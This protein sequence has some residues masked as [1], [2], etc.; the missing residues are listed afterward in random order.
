MTSEV[1]PV[2]F[3]NKLGH[4]LFGMVHR[5]AKPCMSGAAIILLSPGVKM[6][7]A[8]HRLYLD[9]S[10]RFV[11]LGYTVLRFD[12]YGLGD[13]EGEVQEEYLA[14]LYGAVQVGRYI[15]DTIAAMDWMQRTYGVTKFIASGLC[16]GAITGL[17]A[18]VKDPRI[19]G[20][21]GLAIPV[22]IDGSR[23]DFNRYMTDAQLNMTRDG[24][25][26]KLLTPKAWRSW[27]RLL[28]FQSDY[29]TIVRSLFKPVLAKLRKGNPVVPAATGS[30]PADNTNPYFAQAVRLMLSTSRPISLIFA[31]MDRLYW[32][33]EKKFVERN[34]SVLDSYA[35]WYEV[36]VTKDA[37]HIFSF[38]EWED[39]MLDHCTKWLRRLDDSQIGK[40][41]QSE[42][43]AF[44][45]S[46][47]A[48]A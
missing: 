25:L 45:Q 16:G 31:E 35:D 44:R 46:H 48:T 21:L 1:F 13:S 6:R 9:M 29:K 38:R 18:A 32:E 27:I 40:R 42:Q 39:D 10:E 14:D 24:Y 26:R 36:H 15:D 23:I 20:L 12:F 17:L 8:P 2:T 41:H 34:R 4:R 37:N 22:I 43:G 19:I 7:V 47:H 33:F 11:T 30:E 28:T 5:P 3:Q